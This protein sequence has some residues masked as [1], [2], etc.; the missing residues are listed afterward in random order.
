MMV[1]TTAHRRRASA[2]SSAPS[3]SCVGRQ[4]ELGPEHRHRRAQHLEGR[5]FL[6]HLGEHGRQPRGE[7]ALGGHGGGEAA[8]RVRVGELALEEQVPDVFERTRGGEVDGGVLAVVE[9]ALLAPHVAQRRLRRHHALEAGRDLGP[10]LLGGAQPGH[11]HEVP[12]RH[13]TDEVVPVDDGQMPVLVMSQAGPGRVHLFVGP[14]D[15]GVGRHPHL[16]GLGLRRGRRRRGPQE[17][18]L[19]QDAGHL[20]AVGDDDRPDARGAHG[21]G[22]RGQRR[23]RFARHDGRRHE[24]TDDGGHGGTPF[25][26]RPAGLGGHLHVAPVPPV[27]KC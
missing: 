1:G 23:A 10:V 6:R 9:E 20:G 7:V 2:R 27:C 24:V 5:P 19:G 16:D 25:S 11:A 21:T 4:P 18:A 3:M 14:E 12:Q 13:H 22:R 26:R 17:V 8:R 15:V